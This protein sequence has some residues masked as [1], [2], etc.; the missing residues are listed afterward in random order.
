M[1]HSSV[2]G[3]GGVVER[4]IGPGLS[5]RPKNRSAL[6]LFETAAL[7]LSR[8]TADALQPSILPP[9]SRAGLQQGL[10]GKYATDDGR[11]TTPFEISGSLL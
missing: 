7:H 5:W 8:L 1:R 10:Y 6:W 9:V 4:L 3:G 11:Q 2:T